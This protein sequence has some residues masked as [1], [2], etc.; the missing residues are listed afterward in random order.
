M[1]R[2]HEQTPPTPHDS[3]R[4]R[5]SLSLCAN[6]VSSIA[7]AVCFGFTH[8]SSFLHVAVHALLQFLGSGCI[9]ATAYWF[10]ANKYLTVVSPHRC[11][12]RVGCYGQ[13][14]DS[15]CSRPRT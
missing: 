5:P 12:E 4:A 6:Q 9:V 1:T 11:R 10:L 15:P 3:V 13:V 2:H 7:H 14:W 8:L